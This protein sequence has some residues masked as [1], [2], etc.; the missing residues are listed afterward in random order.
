MVV[1]VILCSLVLSL[2]AAAADGNVSMSIKSPLQLNGKQLAPG[3][4]KIR[5]SGNGS[6]LKVSFLIGNKEVLTTNAKLVERAAASP[7]T[8]TM[9]AENSLKEIRLAHKKSVIVFAD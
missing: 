9:T 1:G 7:Y 6:D 8:A 3:D 2:A 5:W 4:Y